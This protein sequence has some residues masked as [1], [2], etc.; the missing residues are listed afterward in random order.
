[1]AFYYWVVRV[2]TAGWTAGTGRARQRRSAHTE[3]RIVSAAGDLFS[4]DGYSATTMAAIAAGAGVAVQ[5]LYLRFGG[6]L[7]ILGAAMDAAIVGDTAPVPLLERDWFARL[8][9]LADGPSAVR[10]FL[11]EM[12]TLMSRTYPLY[13][14]LLRA[15]DEARGLLADNKDQRREG[16]EAVAGVLARKPGFAGELDAAHATDV[17]YGL[18]SEEHF[19]LLVAERGWAPSAWREWVSDVLIAALY[20]ATTA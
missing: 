11:T 4:R 14:V 13:E 16:L 20:P 15:G 8:Q 9:E 19:G 2:S 5:S 12:E 6:K 10:L 1:M 18:V 7:Q 17:L 3:Q